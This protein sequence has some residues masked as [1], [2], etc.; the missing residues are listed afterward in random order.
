MRIRRIVDLS[1]PIGPTT[2]VYPGD[3]QPRLEP[4]ATIGREGYN[5]LRVQIGSQ[6]GTHVDAPYHFEPEGARVSALDLRLFVGPGFVLDLRGLAPRQRISWPEIEPLLVPAAERLGPG[7]IALLCTGWAVHFGT[8]AYLD[9][10]YLDAEAC[11]L[12]L[13]L[14]VRTIGIDAIN[15]DETPDSTHPG[16]G[17]P[18]HHLIARAGGVIAE[19]LHGLE[20]IDFP[21]PLISLLPLPLE[22]AD[23]APVRAVAMQLEV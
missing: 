13:D 6:T 14:G 4:H 12:M 8:P 1:V 10:P 5:L 9:H 16:E 3:P 17:Y 7:A 18:V 20:H 22:D 19:N 21:D 15:V 23:G 11:R 2:Q